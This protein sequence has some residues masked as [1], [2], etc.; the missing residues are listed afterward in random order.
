MAG[1]SCLALTAY[2]SRDATGR[3]RLTPRAQ[4][5]SKVSLVRSVLHNI[6]IIRL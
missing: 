6:N 2:S 4:E 1:R 3:G 5:Q